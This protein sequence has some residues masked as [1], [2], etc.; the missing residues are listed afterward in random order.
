LKDDNGDG[1]DHDDDDDD[2]SDDFLLPSHSNSS[3]VKGLLATLKRQTKN[4]K[5]QFPGLDSNI[6]VGLPEQ[7]IGP[8]Q[9]LYI[10]TKVKPRKT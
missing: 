9:G 1:G 5:L 7:G 2:D 4:I 10:Y 6:M 8:S 3:P